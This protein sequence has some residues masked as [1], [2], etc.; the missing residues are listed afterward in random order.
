MSTLYG[1][2]VFV[3]VTNDISTDQRVHKV[4]NY[5]VDKGFE[6]IV[7]GR[8][9]SSTIKVHRAYKIIR[10]KHWF[11]NN[12][13]FYAE[14]NSRLLWRLLF[15]KYNFI[16]SNDLDTLP[17]CFLGAKIKKSVLI[18][19]CHEYFTEVPELQNRFLVRNIWRL[20]EQLFLPRVKYSTTVSQS[21]INEYKR[22]YGVN[23]GL[24]RN[25]PLLQKPLE[26]KKVNFPTTNKVV[27]YQGVLN[28]GRGIKPMI[29]S[30]KYLKNVD[31]VIIGYGKVKNE[32]VEFVKN[33]NLKNRV[34]FLGRISHEKLYSYTRIADVG[35]VLEEPLGKSF[36]YS[37]P[38][39]LFD[40]IHAEI[41][42]I[43]SPIKEVKKI[44]DTYEVGLTIDNHEPEHI[45]KTISKLLSD[46]KLRERIK[47]NQ[48]Q[49]KKQFS[50]ENEVKI[51][52][53]FFS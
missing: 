48:S 47:V 33:E 26:S 15:S 40:F 21:I 19:D 45:A 22:K 24:L 27:L 9:L 4:C 38:N 17:A 18:Y 5:L 50:W 6:V 39:K 7:Y 51:L 25:L 3:A 14:Y 23:M 28:P 31:L 11:N 30:L 52:E 1:K 13:L 35:M 16:I 2:K 29:K 36:E 49:I 10:Q 8:E 34:H 37:L 20:I 43:A 12:F 53:N 46:S 44:V 42:I 32:L 41:P